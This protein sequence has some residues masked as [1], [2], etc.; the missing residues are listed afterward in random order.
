MVVMSRPLARGPLRQNNGLQIRFL[1]RGLW[2][3]ASPRPLIFLRGG[4]PGLRRSISGSGGTRSWTAGTAP[5]QQ[6]QRPGHSK[7]GSAGMPPPA[8]SPP[9]TSRRQYLLR[10]RR[11]QRVIAGHPA[12]RMCLYLVTET[13]STTGVSPWPQVLPWNSCLLWPFLWWPEATDLWSDAVQRPRR[14][15]LPPYRPGLLAGRP[16]TLAT[17][18]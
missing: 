10:R 9:E 8:S 16:G 12:G 14:I 13:D 5:A 11:S 1:L 6:S 15:P 3:R 17:P 7:G 4:G 18:P 2:S